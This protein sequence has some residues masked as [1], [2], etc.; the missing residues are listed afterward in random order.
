MKKGYKGLIEF[1]F[2]SK[3]RGKGHMQQTRDLR[4]LQNSKSEL[5]IKQVLPLIMFTA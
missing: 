1:Y 4:V 3:L 5:T 2:T